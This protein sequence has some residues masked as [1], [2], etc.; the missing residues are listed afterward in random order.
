MIYEPFCSSSRIAII[1]FSLS[2]HLHH[3]PPSESLSVKAYARSLRNETK[4]RKSTPF[5]VNLFE[6]PCF[7]FFLSFPQSEHEKKTKQNRKEKKTREFK[8][9]AE[10]CNPTQSQKKKKKK[11]KLCW[12]RQNP[13][14]RTPHGQGWIEIFRTFNGDFGGGGRWKS[15]KTSWKGDMRGS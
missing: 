10:L 12:N 6:F 2:L 3:P 9:P 13:L 8:D 5:A 11:W 14:T 1:L 15:Q 4:H 7:S